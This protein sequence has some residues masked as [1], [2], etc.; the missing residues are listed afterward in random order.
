MEENDYQA[1]FEKYLQNRHS[2]EEHALFLRWFNTLSPQEA[3][4]LMEQYAEMAPLWSVLET[5]NQ[6][7]ALIRKIEARLDQASQPNVAETPVLSLWSYL[8]R[9]TAA[10][11]FVLIGLGG[12]YLFINKLQ[13]P[14][15]EQQAPA[16]LAGAPG[17]NKA[18]LTLGDG[19]SINLN[20]AGAG[21]IASQSDIQIYKVKDGQLV[22]SKAL[23]AKEAKSGAAS[24]NQISTPKAGQYQVNLSDGTKVWLNS[25]SSIRFP[26]TFDG[27]ARRVEI[28]GEVY[29]EVAPYKVKGRKIPFMVASNNQVIEVLGTHFNVNT[30]KDEGA[31]KTT[32]LE[33]SVKVYALHADSRPGKNQ[34]VVRLF[35]GEQAILKEN[36]SH[37]TALKV[38]KA[39]TESAIAWQKGYFKFRDTNIQEVMRQLSRWY[40][41]EVVY[42]GPLPQDQFTGYVSKKVAVSNVLNILEEGGGVK[43]NVKDNRVEVVAAE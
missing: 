20:D 24:F 8:R 4:R 27:D 11:V 9:F 13:K 22:Y 10:A 25:L 18:L 12:Y 33:G 32:L 3:E 15:S 21:Q 23:K 35:P 38:E 7:D 14:V 26:A 2:A 42:K 37:S 5:Q 29:F 30:Y 43:F 1:F 17:G 31:V 34:D 39:D 19:S 28:T 36:A 40:D 16:K 41:L 6:N